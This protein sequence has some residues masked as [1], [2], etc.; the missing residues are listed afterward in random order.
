MERPRKTVLVTAEDKSG[1]RPNKTFAIPG[2]VQ[3]RQ[4]CRERERM[5]KKFIKHMKG[6]HDPKL[7]MN[8]YMTGMDNIKETFDP[9]TGAYLLQVL[10]PRH[11]NIKLDE[12]AFTQ[13]NGLGAPIQETT[14]DKTGSPLETETESSSSAPGVI[15]DHIKTWSC[16][17]CGY[18]EQGCHCEDGL[19]LL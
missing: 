12:E 17:Q 8:L 1:K 4:E 2:P 10:N 18:D 16:E 5:A 13:L 6:N 14:S 19:T 15:G 9:K 11:V 3:S 7:I